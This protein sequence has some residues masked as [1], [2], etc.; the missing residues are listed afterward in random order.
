MASCQLQDGHDMVLPC[1][2]Q[3]A[4]CALVLPSRNISQR[5]VDTYNTQPQAPPGS[6]EMQMVEVE[7]LM[8]EE[9]VQVQT[10]EESVEVQ[11]YQDALQLNLR[12]QT[13]T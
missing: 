6:V 5:H 11:K 4:Q 13:G 12:I 7:V 10:V 2:A 8:V 1:P 3:R 9:N